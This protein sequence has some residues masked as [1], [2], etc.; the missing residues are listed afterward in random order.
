MVTGSHGYLGSRLLNVLKGRFPRAIILGATRRSQGEGELS[1][2]FDRLPVVQKLL[3]S[4]RPDII[5]HCVGT[6]HPGPWALLVRAHLQPT[7]HLLEAVRSVAGKKPRVLILGSAA[8]YGS[9][10]LRG[11]FSEQVDPHPETLY[12]VSKSLQ[13]TI[14]MNYAQWG[15]PVLVARIFNVLAP[16]AP[17]SFAVSRVMNLLRK[18]PKGKTGSLRVGPMNSVRD[19]VSLSDAL[20]AL[21]LLGVRGKPGEI[22][23]VCSGKGIRMGD[24][25]AS[26]AEGAGVTVRWVTEERGSLR[27]HTSF[28]VG[29]SGKIRRQVGWV[30]KGNV[31]NEA[32]S[33]LSKAQ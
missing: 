7:L 15:V 22:Y 5:F 33:L 9:G 16:D 1:C 20:G 21:A 10:R 11:R 31:L 14:A 3:V 13:T 12:G 29:D 17:L 27:S 8:E 25:F 2:R 4:A 28:S 19:F 26:L 18:I 32:R 23:N 6:T 30:P 24:L